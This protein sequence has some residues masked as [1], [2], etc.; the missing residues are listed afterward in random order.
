[1]KLMNAIYNNDYVD[2]G[3][4]CR[5]ACL[6]CGKEGM[7]VSNTAPHQWQCWSCKKSGNAY[8]LVQLYYDMLPPLNKGTCNDMLDLKPGTTF[9]AWK[10]MGLRSS[11]RGYVCPCRNSEGKVVAFYRFATD[12]N[13]WISTPKP[14]SLTIMGMDGLVEDDRP[15]LIAEGHADYNVALSHLNVGK[16]HILGLCGSSFPSKKLS[17]LENRNVV[18][19]GDNDEAGRQGSQNL[20]MRMKKAGTLCASL[21]FLDWNLI[22]VQIEEKGDLRDLALAMGS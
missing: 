19:L 4:D 8:T 12:K 5:A 21:R 17:C 1:M 18:F 22:P 7:E 15:I 6:S 10:Q 11:D 3:D 9:K 20:A 14:T 16:Y 13:C 2:N